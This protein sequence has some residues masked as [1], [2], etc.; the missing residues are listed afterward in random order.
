M[1]DATGIA[2]LNDIDCRMLFMTYMH[3][4][5]FLAIPVA[6]QSNSLQVTCTGLVSS[7][8]GI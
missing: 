4:N 3:Y 8:L 5:F 2:C 7:G 1:A 6:D